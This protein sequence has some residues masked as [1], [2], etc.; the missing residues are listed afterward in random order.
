MSQFTKT[1]LDYELIG[2]DQRSIG[3]SIRGTD[4]PVTGT[5]HIV[6]ATTGSTDKTNP[7]QPLQLRG[8]ATL[9]CDTLH[10]HVIANFPKQVS[11]KNHTDDASAFFDHGPTT[12]VIQQDLQH[13]PHWIVRL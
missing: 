9:L 13:A 1:S 5:I 2:L 3:V 7:P 10:I 6:R 4:V 11:Q 8:L 12:P